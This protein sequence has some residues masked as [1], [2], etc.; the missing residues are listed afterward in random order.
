MEKNWPDYD[1]YLFGKERVKMIAV[2][3]S[4]SEQENKL[5]AGFL[6]SAQKQKKT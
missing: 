6:A 1:Q 4:Y 3:H 5:F 2:V